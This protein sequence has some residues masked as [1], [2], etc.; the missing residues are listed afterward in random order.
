MLNGE[1]VSD[2]TTDS[3]KNLKELFSFILRSVKLTP[4]GT[5]CVAFAENLLRL[6]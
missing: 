3:P 6:V 4:K 5:R 1:K 2:T